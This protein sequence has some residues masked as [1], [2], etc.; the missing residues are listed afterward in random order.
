MIASL[1]AHF[2]ELGQLQWHVPRGYSWGIEHWITGTEANFGAFGTEFC[3]E[4]PFRSGGIELTS[5]GSVFRISRNSV[6]LIQL[7]SVLPTR[8]R[9]PHRIGT[10]Y[11]NTYFYGPA[12]HIPST[13]GVHQDCGLGPMFFA[14]VA[15]RVYQKLAAIPPERSHCLSLF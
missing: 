7:N 1:L 9:L 4:I 12:M 8:K 2:G 3:G 13:C 15:S 11:S 14:I 10:G 6:P 5:A